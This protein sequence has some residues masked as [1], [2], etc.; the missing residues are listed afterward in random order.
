MSQ[1]TLTWLNNMT[2]IGFTDKRG[3]AWHYKASEQGDQPNHYPGAIPIE[4]V[5][6]RL[7][8][9][10][11]KEG[12][13]RVD[14]LSPDG[15]T[16]MRDPERKA[17][18]RPAGALGPD[19]E[20]GVLEIFKQGYVMHQYDEWLLQQVAT[21]LDDDLSIGSA[22]LLR[23]GGVAW[24]QVEVPENIETPSGVV[25]RPNLLAATSLDGTMATTYKRCVTNV[26]CDNT[27]AAG[28]TEKGHTLKI[29]HSRYSKVK[30]AEV[31]EALDIVH[32]IA[33]DFA[34]QVE[35]LT[36][37]AVS[38]GDWNKFLDDLVPLVD[39]AGNRKEGRG[40]TLAENKRAKL[41]N[42]WSY[43]ERVAPWAGTAFGV[44]QAVNT[45]THHVQGSKEGGERGQA[46]MLRAV[47]G[48]TDKLDREALA[49]LNKVM[50][51]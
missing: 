13:V 19:D 10:E 32:T 28:L 33:D 44:V 22:G 15:V 23:M 11:A 9:W 14:I 43:D 35:Q 24:V 17:I 6:R 36:N 1:E 49:T 21:I 7:F 30:L 20:G 2:L 12:E 47:T 5:R 41:Q 3:K 39:D 51:A 50:A 29:R 4:D 48:Q 31:R 27:M 38:E 26:V 16:T 45:F 25:F 8:S 37:T 42:L 40:L 34:E 46:N 18:I